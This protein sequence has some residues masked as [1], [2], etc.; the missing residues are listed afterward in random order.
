LKEVYNQ[1]DMIVNN[2]KVGLS[3]DELFDNL[4]LSDSRMKALKGYLKDASYSTKYQE[5]FHK[6]ATK[7]VETDLAITNLQN[8]HQDASKSTD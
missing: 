2:N 4:I 7:L 1:I 6:I 5:E 3:E 8:S